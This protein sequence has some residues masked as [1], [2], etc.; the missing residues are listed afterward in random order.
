MWRPNGNVV[1]DGLDHAPMQIQQRAI[2]QTASQL[3]ASAVYQA[4]HV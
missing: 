3:Y 1:G 4:Q 2:A